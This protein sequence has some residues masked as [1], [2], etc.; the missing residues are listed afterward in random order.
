MTRQRKFANGI[1][2]KVIVRESFR[3]SNADAKGIVFL[4]KIRVRR[5]DL[6]V[7]YSESLNCNTTE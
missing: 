7:V 2:M 4:K 5:D 3:K 1:E 6:K